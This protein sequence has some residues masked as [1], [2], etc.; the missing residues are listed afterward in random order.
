MTDE[1]K[2]GLQKARDLIAIHIGNTFM[3]RTIIRD[4]II[5]TL[6]KI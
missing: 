1:Y 6:N 3:Q 4:A 2:E 5:D